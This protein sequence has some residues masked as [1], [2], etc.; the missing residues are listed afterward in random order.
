MKKKIIFLIIIGLIAILSY[1]IRSFEFVLLAVILLSLIFLILAGIIHAFKRMN[2]AYFK[3]P[4]IIIC[5]SLA[6]IFVSLFRPYE[7]AVLESGTVKEKLA[8]AY[9]TDQGDRQQLR[10]YSRLL[11]KLEQRDEERLAQVMSLH[12]QD[13]IIKPMDK[14][15]AAFI[16]HH[17]DNSK[18]YR[19]ASQL[20]AAAAQDP[21]LKDHYQAQWLARAA[22]DRYMIS[23]G[24][25]EKY[26][27]QNTF[28]LEME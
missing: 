24:K 1:Q 8:Y 26:G 17:S 23:I 10:S 22:Y 20:A 13:Q 3:I 28:S 11:G 5:I 2:R 25:E 6:G 14:F 27:T 7:K 12:Q 19:I 21:A 15:Y 9:A 16:Y 4:V 18:D